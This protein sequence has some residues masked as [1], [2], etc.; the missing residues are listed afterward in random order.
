MLKYW[1]WIVARRI[2]IDN[3]I[4]KNILIKTDILIVKIDIYLISIFSLI[5]PT[6]IR[7]QKIVMS[8]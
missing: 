1:L 7:K 3:E 5:D 2:K 6:I 4:R 8:I